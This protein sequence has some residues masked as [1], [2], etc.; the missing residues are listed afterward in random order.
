MDI[1]SSG[2][3]RILP[4]TMPNREHSDDGRLSAKHGG[5]RNRRQERL[6]IGGALVLCGVG[7]WLA[8]WDWSGEQAPAPVDPQ[9]VAASP[10]DAPQ[11][12]AEQPIAAPLVI[13]D[14]GQSMWSSPTAG[15]PLAW[16]YMPPG[17]QILL[18]LRPSEI[19]AHAEGEKLHAALG[20]GA[21]EGVR[22]IESACGIA[23]NEIDR[24][25][26]GWQI[27]EGRF[28][29]TVVAYGAKLRKDAPAAEGWTYL[30][31][32]QVNAPSLVAGSAESIAD[33]KSLAGRAPPL[34]REVGR[35]LTQ[36]DAARHITLIV[37][38][39]AFFG[40]GQTLL[41]G[42]MFR[43]RE[44]L[45]W[46]LSDEIAA[47][48]FSLHWDEN[49]F[50]ELVFLPT[51][52]VP[53]P[54][55]AQML[56]NRI[57]ASPKLVEDFVLNISVSPYAERMVARLP[58]MM[59][60]LA[61]FSRVGYGRDHLLVRSYLPIAAG[62]NLALAAELAIMESGGAA[63]S[64]TLSSVS[65]DGVRGGDSIRGRLQRTITLIIPRDSLEAALA[66][67]ARELGVEITIIG[68]DLQ[69]DGITKNQSLQL[70]LD[71]RTG[72]EIL[73]EILRQAN[74]DKSATGPSDPRQKLVYV[75]RPVGQGGADAIFITTRSR[76][77][78]RSEKLPAVFE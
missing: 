2:R 78:E 54:K 25:V 45:H 41:S 28:A 64:E 47:A 60:K 44:S 65:P 18:A 10:R 49:F 77:A 51:L 27:T 50:A 43:L 56:S 23:F 42:P 33:V 70:D 76:A 52:D 19:M 1:H 73:V 9:N 48:A 68:A 57:V 71:N 40:E 55:S 5:S 29:P 74:P 7:L 75:I 11:D 4:D 63:A 36:T 22:A 21:A 13:E 53:S 3:P 17:V 12:S 20:P 30:R 61:T 14:D 35:L 72:E 26:I 37:L 31:P 62:H 34:R 39:G 66:Q 32:E 67:L 16:E 58:E 8:N 46:L 15:E 38:P 24:L 69:A 6:I 59:G